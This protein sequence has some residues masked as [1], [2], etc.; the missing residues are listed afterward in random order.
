MAVPR[1][2]QMINNEGG[3]TDGPFSQK[4]GAI[5]VDAGRCL[6]VSSESRHF[7][8]HFL[9]RYPSIHEISSIASP[10]TVDSAATIRNCEQIIAGVFETQSASHPKP[11]TIP[12]ALA[13]ADAGLSLAK[14]RP[15]SRHP[16]VHEAECSNTNRGKHQAR[17]AIG[18]GSRPANNQVIASTCRISV[19]LDRLAKESQP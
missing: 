18:A 1:P 7:F 6:P 3:P 5:F 17:L 11:R 15:A 16:D 8:V 9:R 13:S 2:V 12:R 14:P 19:R 10:A 4:R